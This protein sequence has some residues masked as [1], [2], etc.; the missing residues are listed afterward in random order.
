MA[1]Q[2]TDSK[3][4]PNIV[5]GKS[6]N[7]F[8]EILRWSQ[9][10]PDWQSDALR[11]IIQQQEVTSKDID[12][13]L[14][15]LKL[16]HGLAN[17]KEM[18]VKPERLSQKEI[19]LQ[20]ASGVKITL[21]N[22]RNLKNVNAIVP[23]QS[24][25]FNHTGMTIIYGKN[26]SG[27]SGY[28]RV[29]KKACRA[30]GEKGPIL[31]NVFA[32]TS[33]QTP[34][35]AE[36]EI[37]DGQKDIC[38]KW[39]D[40]CDSLDELANITVFDSH[41]ARVYVDEANEVAY[42][43]YGLDVFN[44]LAKLCESLK[45]NM[46][47][48]M[49]NLIRK[50]NMSRTIIFDL[51]D[52]TPVGNFLKN[53]SEHS[54]I[55]TIEE[56]A[57]MSDEEKTR[58]SNIE[59]KLIEIKV[60]D[61][62]L[63]AEA[64]RTKKRKLERFSAAISAL[65]NTLSQEVTEKIK[66]LQITLDSAIEAAKV[67]SK[68][69]FE[70]EV[71]KGIGS[72]AWKIMF[73]AAKEY[74]EQ[75][76]YPAISFPFIGKDA[77]CVLCCQPLSP[78]AVDRM[79]RFYDFIQDKTESV[80]RETKNA[81]DLEIYKIN[82]VQIDIFGDNAELIRETVEIDATAAAAISNYSEN[83]KRVYNDIKNSILTKKWSELSF[84]RPPIH[85]I[86]KVIRIL[87]E[88]A[89][90]YEKIANPDEKA[91]L[92]KEQ[93]ELTARKKLSEKKAVV[94]TLVADLKKKVRLEEGIRATTTTGISRKNTELMELLITETLK[95]NLK[96][97]FEF[98]KVDY[99]KIDLDN[100][101]RQGVALHKL[102]LKSRITHTV[103]LSDILSE[104]E[105]RAIAIASFMAELKT[106]PQNCGI[107]F[108]D[109]VSSLDHM[110]RELVADRLTIEAGQRQ[111]VIFTHD[112]VFL[113]G[114]QHAC[115][116]RKVDY[117]IQTVWGREDIGTGYCDSNAPWAGQK[118][119]SKIGYLKGHA[120]PKIK[121]LS[122][123]S[124]ER[125]KYEQKIT[126]FMEKLRETWERAIEEVLFCDTIQRYRDSIETNR[127]KG[128]KFE[129][130]DYTAIYEAMGR[131]SKYQ[132]DESPAKDERSFPKPDLL[133]QELKCLEDFIERTRKRNIKTQ[134]Q[135]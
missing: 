127:L 99:I 50:I 53:L 69:S 36:I 43:P 48:E 14:V 131:C 8:E 111:V 90:A 40:G 68:R 104:G 66:K 71:L 100:M 122:K 44:K 67:A 65:Q 20:S 81:Y 121:E 51:Q 37:H 110:R 79:K 26:A 128:V 27:K 5:A 6:V 119:S 126:D 33:S 1:S 115:E 60:N 120:L 18:A 105:Q 55:A 95:Q 15:M 93:E 78:E 82:A 23:G 118:V 125:E 21:K 11:R 132:H 107:V 109:P 97:E 47:N 106:S 75:Y 74:S 17:G 87:E 22:I 91:K 35:E 4:L 130:G 52:N 25:A 2:K 28:A 89:A 98:L 116:N 133:E 29:L 84:V 73:Q 80:Y 45:N 38:F 41:C 134:E 92:T 85:E 59:K 30:R 123:V 31:P 39:T 96:K 135:R 102:K 56:L 3:I 77:R 19:P 62:I 117:K 103:N 10:L 76:A 88:T 7:V 64:L 112:L 54:S 46:Q 58:L 70:H 94:C 24:I 57:N 86:A 13:V 16:Q 124:N 32:E 34:A 83:I 129:D 108:D 42:I 114:L 12:E 63:K 101:G 113:V 49:E 9:G 72:D 61:P